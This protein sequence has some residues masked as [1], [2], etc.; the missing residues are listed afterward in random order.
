MN[1][2][3][4]QIALLIPCYNAAPFLPG[5]KKSILDQPYRLAEI[6]LYD[7]G[8]TDGTAEVAASLGLRC[9]PGE[10]NLGVSVARNRLVA[11]A[12]VPW[13]H[14]CDADDPLHPEFFPK[15]VPYCS[16]N[17]DVVTCDADW[18]ADGSGKV[19]LEWRYQPQALESDPAAY[20]LEH[21]MSLTNTII[22]REC[23]LKVQGC[24][25][26]L[27]MW[28]DADLHFRLARAGARFIHIPEVLSVS[29]RRDTSFSH[30]YKK[31]WQSRLQWL[32]RDIVHGLED[33]LAKTAADELAKAAAGLIDW[34]DKDGAKRAL[35][36]ARQI[37]HRRPHSRHP[38][39][40][41]LRLI[42]SD[43][44]LLRLQQAWRQ[45]KTAR[46]GVGR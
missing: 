23:W 41:L 42:L 27:A 46:F 8:S 43:F 21:P 37:G 26:S 36:L 29:R 33:R 16:A 2:A 17:Y 35:D 13:V 18:I 3:D 30:D 24:D 20:L 40:N 38:L 9:L 14:F 7:D 31:N 34:K 11:A 19:I 1:V 5:L 45:Y 32:E 25:E 22:R 4:V 12:S 15:L 44:S 28:E 39:F 6:I 10:K